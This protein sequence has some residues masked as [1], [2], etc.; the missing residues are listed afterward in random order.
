MA[1]Q[2]PLLPRKRRNRDEATSL[3]DRLSECAQTTLETTIRQRA[4]EIYLQRDGQHGSELD[5]WLQ[6]EKEILAT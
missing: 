6:A 4:H 2:A 5:D 3:K 1:A